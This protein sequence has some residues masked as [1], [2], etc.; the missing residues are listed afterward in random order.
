MINY[1]IYNESSEIPDSK[2][3]QS[4]EDAIVGYHPLKWLYEYEE[5]CKAQAFEPPDCCRGCSNHPTNG[6][7]GI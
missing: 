3:Y 7:T 2:D 5:I 6:G 4:L 1:R